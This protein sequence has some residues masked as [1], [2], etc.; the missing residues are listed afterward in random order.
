[1]FLTFIAE[2]IAHSIGLY[3]SQTKQHSEE[4]S[5]KH[6]FG[7]LWSRTQRAG[8]VVFPV[9]EATSQTSIFCFFVCRFPFDVP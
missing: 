8:F 1:M 5:H 3:Q 4:K 6:L 2:T 7:Q 9:W